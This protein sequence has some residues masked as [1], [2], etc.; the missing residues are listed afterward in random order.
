MGIE[1]S[2]FVVGRDGTIAHVFR[3]VKPQGHADEV[4]EAVAMMD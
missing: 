3:K 4:G 1:R 2:T